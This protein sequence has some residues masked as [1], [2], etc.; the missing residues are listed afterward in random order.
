MKAT[1]ATVL[2]VVGALDALLGVAFGVWAAVGSAPE[3]KW[4]VAGLLVASGLGLM[5]V[6]LRVRA[7]AELEVKR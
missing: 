1:N 3:A 2:L 7:A 6:A 5:F 4:M